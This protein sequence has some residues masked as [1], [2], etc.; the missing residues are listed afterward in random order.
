[1]NHILHV[2]KHKT[3]VD[4]LRRRNRIEFYSC[5]ATRPNPI[6]KKQNND[7]RS[8]CIACN[9]YCEPSL[10]VNTSFPTVVQLHVLKILVVWFLGM[11]LFSM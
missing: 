1:M 4:T 9:I 6:E 10:S 3:I 11:N 8:R 7:F 2:S 5:V